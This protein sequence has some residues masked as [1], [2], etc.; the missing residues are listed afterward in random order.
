VL[1]DDTPLLAADLTLRAFPLRLAFRSDADLSAIPAE[2][3][4]PFKRLDYGDK[5]LLDADYLVR[6]PDSVPLRWLLLGRQGPGP[7]FERAGKVEAL[8]F[9]ALHLV[10]GW[11]VPQM[12]EFRLRA[13]AL[14]GLARDAA[15]RTRRALRT[16]EA[17]QAH[18]FFLG[19]EP[20]K[21]AEAL[22]RFVDGTSR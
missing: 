7:S 22:R 1:S 17:G 12:A 14:P 21:S 4:R 8:G 3:L 11:G 13:L 10:V 9:L 6:P 2:A 18:R 16:L 15:S 19:A 20:R 5:R